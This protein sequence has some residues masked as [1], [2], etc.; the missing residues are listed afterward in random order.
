MRLAVAGGAG[1]QRV[2]GVG[3]REGGYRIDAGQATRPGQLIARELVT[4]EL[5]G[6]EL[7]ALELV[8]REPVGCELIAPELGIGEL[9]I[10]ELGIGELGIGVPG[11]LRQRRGGGE[12]G[13]R[14]RGG[15]RGV[16]DR[17]GTG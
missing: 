11:G 13:R 14:Q 2:D 16:L 3:L 4:R 5:A 6:C 7:I 9:G 1:A 10:G 8:T 17:R 12:R 15:E